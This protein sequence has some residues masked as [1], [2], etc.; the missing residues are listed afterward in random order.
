MQRAAAAA[1]VAPDLE[2]EAAPAA[3]V[4]RRAAPRAV[5]PAGHDTGGGGAV[6]LPPG[7]RPAA[8]VELDLY[9][10]KAA[11]GAEGPKPNNPSGGLSE[12][13]PLGEGAST[14]K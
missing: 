10:G 4:A 7:A 8:L 14:Q 5:P 6:P 11:G 3:A 13:A 9:Q 12:T 2:L 1:A